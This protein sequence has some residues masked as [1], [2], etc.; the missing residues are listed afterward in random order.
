M[1][2]NPL[3]L[4]RTI[5]N[6]ILDSIVSFVLRIY[7]RVLLSKDHFL[8]VLLWIIL[9]GAFIF[10]IG[11]FCCSYLV[12]IIIYTIVAIPVAV[13]EIWPPCVQ[14]Q[15]KMKT[16]WEK[17]EQKIKNRESSRENR[18]YR[19][20]NWNQQRIKTFSLATRVCVF[21]AFSNSSA[22]LFGID[23]EGI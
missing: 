3:W 16:L 1:T 7:F 2:N 6:R 14:L 10:T 21:Y 15:N 20:L 5:Y 8:F 13:F 11:V 9:L 22:S 17:C 12:I 18:G 23:A 19:K 4:R